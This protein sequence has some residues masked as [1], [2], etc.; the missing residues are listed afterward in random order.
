MPE[1]SFTRSERLWVSRKVTASAT[2]FHL[3]CKEI[4][5]GTS[6]TLLVISGLWS[7]SQVA[8]MAGYRSQCL[9]HGAA[10]PPR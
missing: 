7:N 4:S 8:R 1:W 5:D 9:R 6:Q 3:L 2:A 10:P